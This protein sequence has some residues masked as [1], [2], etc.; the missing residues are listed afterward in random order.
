M[1]DNLFGLLLTSESFGK[2]TNIDVNV[3]GLGEFK[4]PALKAFDIINKEL[5]KN[6]LYTFQ[7]VFSAIYLQ[8]KKK[9]HYNQKDKATIAHEEFH[10]EMDELKLYDPELYNGISYTY[11]E[12]LNESLARAK[13]YHVILK[14]D[15]KSNIQDTINK[16][17]LWGHKIYNLAKDVLESKKSEKEVNE[18][19]K[20]SFC[21]HYD[22]NWLTLLF[23]TKYFSFFDSCFELM[24]RKDNH[25]IIKTLYSKL[26]EDSTGKDFMQYLNT[27][28]KHKKE[29]LT[30]PFFLKKVQKSILQYK[31]DSD[32]FKIIFF[33]PLEYDINKE[34][35]YLREIQDKILKNIET[36]LEDLGELTLKI[37]TNYLKMG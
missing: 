20:K 16:M 21:K 30:L 23:E 37:W 17:S 5:K 19:I 33:S 35:C 12:I 4:K 15:K 26:K 1:T 29:D 10:K 14:N 6:N 3:L 25:E 2:P 27:F 9:E 22:Y 32:E 28:A 31:N 34:Y 24:K 11:Y 36:E 8:H 18:V 13:E 7:T